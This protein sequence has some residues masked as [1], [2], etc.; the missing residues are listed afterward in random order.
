MP[1]TVATALALRL[2]GP[3]AAVIAV[4]AW[5]AAAPV[6]AQA[7]SPDPQFDTALIVAV[8]VSG[9]V[10]EAR[11]RLQMDGI[12]AALE[13]KDVIA[14]ILGGP[15]GGILLTLVAWSDGMRQML[16]WIPVTT[17]EAALDA[18]RQVRA[19]PPI[20]GE[21]TCLARMLG[22]LA[23]GLVPAVKARAARVVIDVSGD[24]PDNCNS[25][26]AVDAA[27]DAAVA[28][29][30]TVNG[31]PILDGEQFRGAMPWFRA[32]GYPDVVPLGELGSKTPEFGTLDNWYRD[33]V[34]GGPGSFVLAADG[35]AD[36]GRAIRRKFTIE[37]SV[38]NER[39]QSFAGRRGGDNANASSR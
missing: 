8:D 17:R 30:A 25:K 22:N 24:G 5:L 14:T 27:R 34:Q 3:A 23:D 31:L 36:F 37:I 32:P 29:G 7:Q 18:A 15:R 6:R 33:H 4:A 35:Y 11:Y 39:P 16:P 19:L 20:G 13:D 1:T 2:I 28:A 9:S 12:A 21:Y 38:L 26:N 10:D